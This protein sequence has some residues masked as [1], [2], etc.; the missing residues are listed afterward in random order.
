MKTKGS[1]RTFVAVSYMKDGDFVTDR[2]MESLDRA[3]NK[4]DDL[5]NRA[6]RGDK[7]AVLRICK[8]AKMY[9]HS[10]TMSK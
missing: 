2:F 1:F 10:Y 8:L 9:M 7:K 4:A 5:W 3:Y 6:T